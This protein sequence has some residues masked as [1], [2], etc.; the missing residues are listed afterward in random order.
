MRRTLPGA[1]ALLLLATPHAVGAQTNP[2]DADFQAIRAGRALFANRCAECHGADARGFSGPDLTVMWAALGTSDERVF[3][4]IRTGVSGSIMPSS[5]APDHEVWAMVAWVKS[6][7]TVDAAEDAPG[8]PE[9]GGELVQAR[10]TRCHTVDGVGGRVGPD[11]S[12][13]GA[14][15]T[16]EALTMSI[17][18]PGAVIPRGYRTVTLVTPEGDSIRGAAKGEDAFSIQILDTRQRLRGYLKTDLADVV[19]E[20]GSLMPAFT[21]ARLPEEDLVDI[22]RYLGTLRGNR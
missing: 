16:R 9:R 13:I 10:C 8:D 4:T 20:T 12:R 22:L 3:Q 1:L 11:L 17:R 21:E 14:V 19:R 5:T 7:S 2:Y 6:I 18:D 15:R